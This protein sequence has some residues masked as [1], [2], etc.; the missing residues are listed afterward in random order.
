MNR[1]M[2]DTKEINS[3]FLKPDFDGKSGNL[4][5]CGNKIVKI[6]A[7]EGQNGKLFIPPD[8]NKICDFSKYM[9]DTIVFPLQYIYENGVIVGEISKYIKSKHIGESFNGNAKIKPIIDSYEQV[10]S[11]MQLYDN[12][13][14]RDLCY[15]NILYSN[16]NGFHL[17]DTTD[18]QYK[19]NSLPINIY[20]FDLS[21][22]DTIINYA[23]I[24]NYDKQGRYETN[25]NLYKNI[26]KYGNAGKRLQNNIDL[27]INDKYRF[28][29]F[30]FAFMEVYQIH[31]S[32]EM[33]SLKELKEM[34]K[35]LKKG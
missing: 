33:K 27:I 18:W 7:K 31:Y 2:V 13:D 24:M 3:N 17:I 26:A 20:R 15:V 14:M 5:I 8:P 23:K 12:I 4:Y 21:L 29:E 10:R 9:A 19:D 22:T 11:D 28:L 16:K 34:T 35:V 6:Y 30:L 25:E 32:E 1:G